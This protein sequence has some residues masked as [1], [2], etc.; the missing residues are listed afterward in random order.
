MNIPYAV[1]TGIGIFLKNF[2]RNIYERNWKKIGKKLEKNLV[3]SEKGSIFA[4][5]NETR[6]ITIK[7]LRL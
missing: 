6:S 4:K 1:K 3:N 5:S 7:K 2:Q